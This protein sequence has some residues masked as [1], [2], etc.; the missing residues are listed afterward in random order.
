MRL[1]SREVALKGRSSDN[2]AMQ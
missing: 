1:S 2:G